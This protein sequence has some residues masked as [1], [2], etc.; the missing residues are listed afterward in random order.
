[1]D[2]I[3]RKTNSPVTERRTLNS[4]S[5]Q[6][7]PTPRNTCWRDATRSESMCQRNGLMN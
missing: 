2:L 4:G 1:M 5:L 7:T 3:M 6:R